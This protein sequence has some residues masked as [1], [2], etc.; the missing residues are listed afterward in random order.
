M[1]ERDTP[2][3]T[4]SYATPAVSGSWKTP[5]APAEESSDARA[6]GGL[7]AAPLV[8]GRIGSSHASATSPR[9]MSTPVVRL[10]VW[11]P[12]SHSGKARGSLRLS[13]EAA[14]RAAG[15]CAELGLPES[16]GKAPVIRTA[17][18]A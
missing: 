8:D 13:A 16:A 5:K 9:N 1:P 11:P 18:V 3:T 12:Q 2:Y 4:C 7:P 6:G 15:T 17:H 14:S 10:T